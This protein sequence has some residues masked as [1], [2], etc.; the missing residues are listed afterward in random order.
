MH[1]MKQTPEMDHIQ[2]RMAPGVITRDG[3]LGADTR[4]LADILCEDDA[5]VHRL[6]LTHQ[7]IA[8]RMIELRD[9]GRAGLG[10]LI[11][12][13]ERFAVRVDEVRGRLACPFG[14]PGLFQKTNTTVRNRISGEEI[15]YTDLGIHLVF[16][17]GFYQGKG[18]PFRLE[19]EALAAFLGVVEE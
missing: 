12:V 8:R 1:A 3:F 2:A 6:D 5:A 13:D 4:H 15:L 19:P 10:E 17:H 9:A 18:S 7:A 16:A 14:D 11:T